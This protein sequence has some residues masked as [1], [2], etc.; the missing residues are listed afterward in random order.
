MKQFTQ[1]YIIK[2]VSARELALPPSGICMGLKLP[3]Y[4]T[5]C[6]CVHLCVPTDMS[7]TK[8]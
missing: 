5:L 8:Q 6:E 1:H 2:L 7:Q 4:K 3:M